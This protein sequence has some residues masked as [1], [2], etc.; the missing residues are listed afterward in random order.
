MKPEQPSTPE[1][2]EKQPAATPRTDANTFPAFGADGAR[3]HLEQGNKPW[4][5][6]DADFARQ[7]ERELYG[8]IDMLA[9]R[10]PQSET[11]ALKTVIADMLPYLSSVYDEGPDGEGW[12]SEKLQ[13]VISRAE[14]SIK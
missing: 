12:Q 4:T 9:A 11:E 7:L 8:A 6:V 2:F 5:V 3:G 13:A 1:V 10:A 14:E